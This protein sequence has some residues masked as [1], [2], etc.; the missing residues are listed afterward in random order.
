MA[1]SLAASLDMIVV[2]P[3]PFEGNG[4]VCPK[5][6][7]EEDRPRQLGFN[8]FTLDLIGAMVRDGMS[9][10]RRYPW[11]SKIQPMIVNHL[12]PYLENKG[13]KRFAMLGFCFGSWV[14]MKACND[15]AIAPRVTCGIHFH[16]SSE[17]IEKTAFKRD[18]IA[19]CHGCRQPQ[20]I[21]ATK[22]ESNKWKP[23]G[24]AHAALQDNPSVAEVQ[25][26]LAPQSQ[27]H[28]FMTRVDVDKN[29]EG[30]VAVKEGLALAES[31]LR[32]HNK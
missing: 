25:F 3:D 10:M 31:F 8:R 27:S 19:L 32:K 2:I 11:E 23:N 5:Y 30:A 20:L 24:A 12:I 18:D 4:G 26:S 13:V 28:G 21:H 22:H 6:G 29:K 17:L 14:I 1:D 16:P 15:D 7:D 9:F